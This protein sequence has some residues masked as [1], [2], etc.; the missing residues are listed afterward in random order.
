[1]PARSSFQILLLLLLAGSLTVTAQPQPGRIIIVYGSDTS[2][3]NGLDV[4]KHDTHFLPEMYTQ[5]DRQAALAMDSTFRN[6]IR[7]SRGKPLVMTW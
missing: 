2:I 6:S 5:P 1:M 4:R 3:D 7:D